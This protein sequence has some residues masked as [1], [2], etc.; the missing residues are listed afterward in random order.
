[1]DEKYRTNPQSLRLDIS[2]REPDLR[3]HVDPSIDY[4]E[5]EFFSREKDDPPSTEEILQ[6]RFQ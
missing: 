3:A 5:E 4:D 2:A 1:M 6:A